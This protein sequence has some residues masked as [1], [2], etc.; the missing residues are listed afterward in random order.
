MIPFAAPTELV[1][2]RPLIQMSDQCLTVPR[3]AAHRS[4]DVDPDR[5]RRSVQSSARRGNFAI[6]EKVVAALKEM[7]FVTGKDADVSLSA[8]TSLDG[9]V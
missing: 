9:E 7:L 8:R 3:V 1:L 6:G 5:R 4:P 2:A